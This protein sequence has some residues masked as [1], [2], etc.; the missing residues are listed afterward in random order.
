MTEVI[1]LQDKVAYLQSILD[2][3]GK[4]Q[5]IA[6]FEMD[7]TLI[8]ANPMFLN[9]MGYELSEVQGQHHNLFLNEQEKSA[10]E[11]SHFW[12]ALNRGEF[13][14]GE[15][16][17][18]NKNGTE[19]WLQ[20][21]Y[22]PLLDA[23]G[24]PLKVIQFAMD[25]SEQKSV[26]R[27]VAKN[28]RHLSDASEELTS[29]SQHMS[30]NAEETSS[31]SNV[32]SAAAEQVN[33]NIEVVTTGAEEMTF[34]IK[35]IALNAHEAAKVAANAVKMAAE[36]NQ[37]ISRLGDSSAE[38]G[39]VIRVIT[40]IAQQTKLLALNATIEAARAGEAGKGFAVVANEVK[41]LAKETATATEDISGKIEAIQ[42]DT[43]GAVKAIADIQTI[44]NTVNDIQNT[45]ASAVEEQAAT[46]SEISRNVTE[47]AKGSHEIARNIA[48]VAEAARSTS[49][50]A[51]EAQ[52]AASALRRMAVSLQELVQ[53]F[54]F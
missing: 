28:A 41:E 39:K 6:E 32:V 13:Q 9:L 40:S 11:Y 34:S 19:V 15:F 47:A 45:I 36:T 48:G 52:R 54:K 10:E 25:V 44:I 8:A 35:E 26:L 37:L 38:I 43:V 33:R 18:L 49:A 21:S 51:G 31:Q 24:K 42:T 20:A 12:H 17:H 50:G 30:S 14:A 29:V 3:I 16:K 46:T 5:A 53:K 4:S 1:A 2:A 23:Q 7:G 27:T 22:N